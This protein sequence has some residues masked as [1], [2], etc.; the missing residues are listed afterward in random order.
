MMKVDVLQVFISTGAIFGIGW[1]SFNFT[2][3][4]YHTV[5]DLMKAPFIERDSL[6]AEEDPESD[7]ES[8]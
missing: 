7:D 4:V 1:I 5:W 2:E 6:L 8:E 3:K